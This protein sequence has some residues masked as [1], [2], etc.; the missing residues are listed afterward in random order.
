MFCD[1]F[2]F[3]SLSKRKC[4]FN[5]LYT[6]SL[7]DILFHSIFLVSYALAGAP[8]ILVKIVFRIRRGQNN[9]SATNLF[10][11]QNDYF[12]FETG[13]LAAYIYDKALSISYSFG[14]I[15]K[16]LFKYFYASSYY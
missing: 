7:L 10:R 9:I 8:K 2:I 11:V 6:I 16:P 12:L 14:S 1:N 3:Y 4:Q 13:F 15:A 5:N